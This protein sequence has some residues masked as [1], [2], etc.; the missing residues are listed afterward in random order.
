MRPLGTYRLAPALPERLTLL[1]PLARDLRV[2]W[3]EDVRSLYRDIDPEEW[4]RSG[5]P[6]ILLRTADP[7]RL[8]ALA[9]DEA[10]VERVLSVA[11]ALDAEDAAPPRHAIAAALVAS[12]DR[13]AYF[14]AEFGLSE[15]LPVYSGGLGVLAG[16]HLKSSSD[17]GV[18]VVGVGLF[19]REGFFRQTLTADAR[20]KESYPIAELH[21][22]PVDVLPTPAG[23]AP[24]VSV[25]LGERDVH[26]LVRRVRVGRSTLLL[27]DSHLP[28]NRPSDREITNRLYGGDKE[29]RIRQELAL[30]IGGMRALDLAGLRPTVRHANEGH[31]AFLGLERIRQLRAE[32]GL[33]FEEA[34]EIAMAGNVFTTHTPVAAGI[35]LFPLELMRKYFADKVDDYGI[36]FEELLGLGRQVPEDPHEFFSMAVLGLRLSAHVN[37]VSKLHAQVSRRL[38]RGVFPEA[39]LSEIPIAAVTNGVHPDTWTAPSITALGPRSDEGADRNELW[40]RHEALRAALVHAVRARTAVARQRRGAPSVEI[41]G[42]WQLL[43]PSALTIGF[44]RRFAT[45]KRA[46]LI[47][48]DPDRLARLVD[49]AHRPIQLL[50]AG[51]AHPKDEPGK[52]FLRRVGEFASQPE[53]R[54]RVV[55]LDDYD[56]RLARLLVSGSDVW[57]NNPIRPNE[58]SGT[59]GM[60]AAMNGVLNLSVLDGW[61]DEAP[62]EETG[63]TLGDDTDGR[64]DDDVAADLYDRLETEVV[65]LF[66]DRP[67][68][69]RAQ[70][71]AAWV[72]RMAAAASRLGRLFSSDRMVGDYLETSYAPAVAR[73]RRLSENEERGARELAA[74]KARARVSWDAVEFASVT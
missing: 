19:Y 3:R 7:A 54:G 71:P 24:I 38:W 51:K 55:L 42:A 69:D 20:Q 9:S 25:R 39:P 22:L 56:M 21:D 4:D 27:L 67:G 14:C 52:E 17:L 64:A 59:S 28:A 23:V 31:A 5:N 70:M 10:Y 13:I 58:A 11:R 12:G 37:G 53:F 18:P 29:M 57:L 40:R 46:T 74:W 36:S 63:F 72:E 8:A 65:P 73:V 33:S 62:R 66:Y 48:H 41:E 49:D 61:W 45:Y 43:D 15:I 68:R 34:R 2:T 30:G 1:S 47:F 60:K 6:I 26:L 16:D 32:R 35:D 44:A 50:F